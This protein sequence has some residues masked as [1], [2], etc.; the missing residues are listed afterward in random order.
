MNRTSSHPIEIPTVMTNAKF[1][2]FRKLAFACLWFVVGLGTSITPAAV[3]W[4]ESLNGDLPPETAPR[5]LN[6]GLGISEILGEIGG[7]PDIAG[8]DP[9]DAFSFVVPDGVTWGHFVLRDYRAS[10]PNDTTG[11]AVFLG[12]DSITGIFLNAAP[13]A[14]DGTDLLQLLGLPPLG[15]GTYTVGIREFFTAGNLYHLEVGLVPEPMGFATSAAC[16]LLFTPFFR[17]RFRAAG[18]S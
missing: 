15:P 11:F 7:D 10:P 2:Q 4:N 17:R 3:V 9:L 6:L 8:T 1:H 14:V 5:S 18:V 12:S 16:L 13:A